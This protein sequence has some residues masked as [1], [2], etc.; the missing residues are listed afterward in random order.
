M[1]HDDEPPAQSGAVLSDF[2]GVA[3]DIGSATLPDYG[4]GR[5]GGF[6][7]VG[8]GGMGRVFAAHDAVLDRQ[9]AYKEVRPDA[10]VR[11]LEARLVGEARITAAIGH[12]GVLPIFDLGRQSDGRLFY[13]MPLAD[14]QTLA[15][16]IAACTERPE[17]RLTLVRRVL[18]ACEA[19]AAAHRKDVIHRDIKPANIMIGTSGGTWVLDWGLATHVIDDA[20]ARTTGADGY[21][22]TN[23]Q[24]VG[25]AGYMSPEQQ[26]GRRLDAR[27]DVYSLGAVLYEVA[28]GY[29]WHLR[30]S[31]P[32]IAESAALSAII[33][34]A[35]SIDTENRYPDAAALAED[36][37]RYL[38]GRRVNAYVYSR[39]ELLGRFARAWRVHLL[40]TAT[41]LLVVAAVVATALVRLDAE[42][43]R[44][45]VAEGAAR[46]ALA[47]AR[48]ALAASK[49]DEAMLHA[50][51]GIRDKAELL[52]AESLTIAESPMA[53]GILAMFGAGSRPVLR[54]VNPLPPCN[55]YAFDARGSLVACRE[56]DGMSVWQLM[57][58][59]QL[60]RSGGLAHIMAFADDRLV[61]VTPGRTITWYE[62]LTGEVVSSS[63]HAYCA[64][65]ITTY[66]D[67]VVLSSPAC[68]EWF[69][70][71]HGEFQRVPA[72]PADSVLLAQTVVPSRQTWIAT[73]SDGTW[74]RGQ[75]G[76]DAE[77]EIIDAPLGDTPALALA[78]TRSGALLAGLSN[79]D[80]AV[81]APS[82]S[83]VT[84]RVRS[85]LTKVMQ[86]VAADDSDLV[87]A[88]GAT[89]GGRIVEP[90]QGLTRGTMPGSSRDIERFH[91]GQLFSTSDGELRRW[92]LPAG[93]PSGF[94]VPDGIVHIDISPDG[95]RLAIT[96]IRSIQIRSLED[97][98]LAA[99]Y[100]FTDR[101]LKSGTFSADGTA[102]FE[103]SSLKP[104]LIFRDATTLA[105]L[106]RVPHPHVMRRVTS[107]GK[108]GFL[109]ADFFGGALLFPPIP[110]PPT[111][112]LGSD[113]RYSDVS[114]HPE[115][116]WAVALRE[117]DR[118]VVLLDGRTRG[119]MD[120][121]QDPQA[122]AVAT[123]AR[124]DIV[125]SAGRGELKLWRGSSGKVIASV[126]IPGKIFLDVAI[127][128]D[129]T[130]V[131]A[132][133]LDGFVYIW[134]AATGRTLVKIEAHTERISSVAFAPHG[135]QL[136]SGSW[137]GR[138]RIFELDRLEQ[139]PQA[140]HEG[141]ARGWGVNSQAVS[142]D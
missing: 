61:T 141:V 68:L 95:T 73:C 83:E 133:T 38:D 129:G 27:T 45:V 87:I 34:R 115:S 8:T 139:G 37:A 57:P 106:Q 10:D 107:L 131:A 18:E 111:E 136:L 40:A 46:E 84:H 24:G 75:L 138:V 81:V 86:L 55:H 88:L 96:T 69:H 47:D 31:Q 30:E 23:T 35:T 16:A 22:T 70:G 142:A 108:F 130:L 105:E 79:G 98:S 94:D 50:S 116:G 58:L 59:R 119:V 36:L 32:Q 110:G 6:I 99:E 14:G 3:L 126:D 101:L 12:P 64:D 104:E 71:A 91:D 4:S 112:L 49:A 15:D 13:T 60:W 17:T 122:V 43:A 7:L 109:A 124:G 92:Q 78:Y 2:G 19:V 90:M 140:I 41:A 117:S 1:K 56:N 52:A 135:R 72:C 29:A 103:A 137:D 67:I 113:H 125:A 48:T 62:G 39:R 5:Y 118:M 42:R 21:S 20:P 54:G 114:S 128:P 65:R 63:P 51:A 85:G 80:I 26:H 33:A 120:V 100:S 66:G 89:G 93:P 127:S 132:G 74:A 25:T 44:A 102:L 121:G 77:I 28:T 82:L 76:T 97:G 123:G 134:N 11:S 53:R 9:V